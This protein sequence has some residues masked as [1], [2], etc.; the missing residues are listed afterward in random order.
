MVNSNAHQGDNCAQE[1]GLSKQDRH[2]NA[3]SEA[4]LVEHDN[5]STGRPETQSD[6]DF[7]ESLRNFELR[8]AEFAET[9]NMSNQGVTKVNGPNGKKSGRPIRKLKPNIS[10]DWLEDVRSRSSMLTQASTNGS[11]I[12][13]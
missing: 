7:E 9:S 5:D 10:I 3:N 4:C 12:S 1:N 11:T 2:A 13:A 6:A 8:L